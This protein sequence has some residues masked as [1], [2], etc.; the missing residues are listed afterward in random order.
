MSHA[1]SFVNW[2]STL[3]LARGT[4]RHRE[5]RIFCT[6]PAANGADNREGLKRNRLFSMLLRR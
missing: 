1:A 2:A 5:P 6:R 3:R 4:R